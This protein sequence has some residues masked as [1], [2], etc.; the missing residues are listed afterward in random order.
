MHQLPLDEPITIIRYFHAPEFYTF[1][2]LTRD[3]VFPFNTHDI[4]VARGDIVF[5]WKNGLQIDPIYDDHSTFIIHNLETHQ[6]FHNQPFDK[7]Q[8]MGVFGRLP[9]TPAYHRR[10]PDHQGAS[11]SRQRSN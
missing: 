5:G 2:K 6:T 11:A 3:G 8:T 4:F 1:R 7:L 10:F 9:P